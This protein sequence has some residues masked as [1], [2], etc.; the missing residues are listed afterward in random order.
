VA[1]L[2]GRG[3]LEAVRAEGGR[4]QGTH[5]SADVLA[6]GRVQHVLDA[7]TGGRLGQRFGGAL[8]ARLQ[9][10]FDVS[11]SDATLAALH[12]W[13]QAG[14]EGLAAYLLQSA[15]VRRLN[16][17]EASKDFDFCMQ[18]DIYPQVLPRWQHDRLLCQH[19]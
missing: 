4:Q 3:D 17:L 14:L 13:Q 15:H 2:G 19:N 12:L 9:G 16:S 11:S 1:A 10:E 6:I 5:P 7:A 18:I 8:A